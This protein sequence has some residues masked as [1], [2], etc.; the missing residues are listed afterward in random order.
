LKFLL[1]GGFL[2]I[3]LI[4]GCTTLLVHTE[5]RDEPRIERHGFT[6]RLKFDD[7]IDLTYI[8]IIGLGVVPSS[9]GSI[10]LGFASE[11]AV[12]IPNEAKCRIVV[13][14][15]SKLLESTEAISAIAEK[16]E[17]ICIVNAGD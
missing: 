13:L 12:L 6:T 1:F 2:S 16:R 5:G 11:Q 17:G 7:D 9:T 10:T 3:L 14:V 4:T 8:R 15:D